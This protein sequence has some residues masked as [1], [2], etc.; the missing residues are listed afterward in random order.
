MIHSGLQ[1]VRDAERGS[2]LTGFHDNA[3]LEFGVEVQIF[4]LAPVVR[5]PPFTAAAIS[6]EKFAS[7][8]RSCLPDGPKKLMQMLS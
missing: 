6:A 1:D 4:Q 7:I 3:S 2:T 5:F 8:R